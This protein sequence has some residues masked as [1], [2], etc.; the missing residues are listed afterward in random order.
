MTGAFV[1]RWVEENEPSIYRPITRHIL[2]LV[3]VAVTLCALSVMVSAQGPTLEVDSPVEGLN[4][5]DPV[6]HVNGTTDPLA[7]VR[8]HVANGT[9]EATGSTSARE[10]GTFDLHVDLLGGRQEL[11]VQAEDR[12]GN[13]TNVTRHVVLDVTEPHLQVVMEHL[14]HSPV[15]WNDVLGGYVVARDEI[16]INGTYW[17]DLSNHL[18]LTLRFNGVTQNIFLGLPGIIYERWLL[19]EGPNTLII[20]VTDAA[21][22]MA[23]LRLHVKADT[24]PPVLEVDSPLQGEMTRNATVMVAGRTEPLLPVV[25]VVKSSSGTLTYNLTSM[26]DGE[27]EVPVRPYEGH[28]QFLVTATD[29]AGNPTQVTIEIILDTTPSEFVINQPPGDPTHTNIPRYMIVGTLACECIATILIDDVEVLSNTGVFTHTVQ[30]EEGENRVSVR[31]VDQVGNEFVVVLTFFLDTGAPSLVVTSPEVAT[32]I[33]NDPIVRFEGSVTG[34]SIVEVVHDGVGYPAQLSRGDWEDGDWQYHLE[35]GPDDLEQDVLVRAHDDV[36]NEDLWSVHVV[37][38]LVPPTLVIDPGTDRTYYSSPCTIRGTT[39]EDAVSVTANGF[40]GEVGDGSFNVTFPIEEGTLS[41]RI[42]VMDAAG[43]VASVTL[44]P[45]S[46]D[47]EPPSCKLDY[48]STKDGDTATI[49]GTCSEDVVELWVNGEVHSVTGG[50]FKV[51]VDLPL[52]GR[53]SFDITLVDRAGNVWTRTITITKGA[54]T[55]TP[56]PGPVAV[57]ATLALVAVVVRRGRGRDSGETLKPHQ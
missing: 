53:N 54:E 46:L 4:T 13:L 1:S 25:V 47:L 24:I 48:P 11:T 39:S 34:A 28:L 37:L 32:V 44:T 52:D 23:T 29:H 27:F 31:S 38:D 55:S 43:N 18:N 22:N 50:R 17:D 8:L 7:T 30:L 26:V 56:G 33:T 49:E 45:I 36:G 41:I 5:N 2:L 16:A 57:L 9:D 42:V 15:L 12:T 40:A 10:D 21:G 20:D 51:Q 6:L 14:D 3:F 19:A 35:L